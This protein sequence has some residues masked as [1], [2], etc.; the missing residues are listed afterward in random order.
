MKNTCR[1]KKMRTNSRNP[2]GSLIQSKVDEEKEREELYFH[3][4]EE[5]EDRNHLN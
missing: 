4:T 3:F 2:E 1:V 5:D